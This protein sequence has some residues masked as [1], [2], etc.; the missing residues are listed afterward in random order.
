MLC[1]WRIALRKDDVSVRVCLDLPFI[2][3]FPTIEKC[4][5]EIP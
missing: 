4:S 1:D 2:L 5:F 3:A